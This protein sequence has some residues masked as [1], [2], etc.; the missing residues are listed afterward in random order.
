MGRR[1]ETGDVSECVRLVLLDL[2]SCERTPRIVR[3]HRNHRA[4]RARHAHILGRPQREAC[5]MRHR[6]GWR[7]C[8]YKYDGNS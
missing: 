5:A 1:L 2:A 4:W 3:A 6:C 8:E 7:A